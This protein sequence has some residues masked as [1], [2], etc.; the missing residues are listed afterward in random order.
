MTTSSAVAAA[1]R[2]T[3]DAK[4]AEQIAQEAFIYFYSLMSME[5]TR[6]QC[7]NLELG[8]RPGFGPTNV[9]SHMREYP[10]ADF[11]TVVRP[12]FDTLYSI[13]WLDLKVEPMILSVP[14]TG[15][16]YYLLPMLDMWTDV[17][18]APGWRTSGSGER[19]FAVVAPG[20]EGKL[21]ENVER[22]NAP[23]PQ[24]W[25]VGRTKT[26]GPKDYDAVHA[27]QDQ[28]KLTPL[29]LWG[30]NCSAQPTFQFDPS[31]D[32]K[33]PPLEQ[34]NSMKAEEY[35]KT[36]ASLMKTHAP[37][38]TDWSTLE[39]IS[40][41]GLQPGQD[42]DIKTLT[43]ELQAALQKGMVSGLKVLQDN[44]QSVGKLVNGW[45][46]NVDSIGVYGSSYMKRAII[47]MIGLGANQPDDAVY[48]MNIVDA[49]GKPLNGTNN[50][51]LHFSKE[52]L[53]PV[54]AFWSVTMYDKDGFQ[55]ANELNRFAISSWMDL[56]E[57]ADGSLDLYLQNSNPGADKES[58]WLPAPKTELGVTLRLYAPQLSVHSGQWS[59]PPIKRV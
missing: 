58:N 37:H 16:R 38:Y 23:T 40:R 39:R 12:N 50:Y 20:W 46:V 15:D 59:P 36:A 6:R 27:L 44:K 14:E 45:I 30:K 29:S 35:F 2:L 56:K 54:N 57:N 53:P 19:N 3:T 5:A 7:T 32:M 33:T 55:A 11:K 43:P 41:I 42:F 34:I 13:A 49:D 28:F 24:A 17:F 22:I 8:Q 10:T 1:T 4:E 31:V 25:I 51:V 26:D 21:P 48:P 52:Q 47:S 9:F 18:A